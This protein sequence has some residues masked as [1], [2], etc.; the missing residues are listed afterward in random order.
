MMDKFRKLV[1]LLLVPSLTLLSCD[2]IG[3]EDNAARVAPVRDFHEVIL[4]ESTIQIE[5]SDGHVL[6]SPRVRWEPDGFLVS[7]TEEARISRYSRDGRLEW[8]SGRRGGGPGEYRAAVGVVRLPSGQVLAADR[9]YKF[10]YLSSAGDTL[11]RTVS[12]P[13]YHVESLALLTDS[14]LLVT[15]SSTD[16]TSAATAHIWSLSGDSILT[17]FFAPADPLD[18]TSRTAGWTV[19]DVRDDRIALAFSTRDTIYL[20]DRDGREQGHLPLRT[21]NFRP[22]N[23]PPLAARDDPRERIEWVS[24]FDLVTG[25]HLLSDGRFLATYRSMT[26]SGQKH[27]YVLLDR[28]GN[29]VWEVRDAPRLLAVSDADSFLIVHPDALAP[30]VWLVARL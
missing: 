3:N 23:V 1:L 29:P 20:F 25:I 30:N 15:S 19:A 11:I 13:F 26:Q 18:V 2:G 9:N 22:V 28:D 14:T 21:E 5:E 6:V 10:V 27:H 16:S 4:T 24:S 7:D 12:T 8:S 17:S